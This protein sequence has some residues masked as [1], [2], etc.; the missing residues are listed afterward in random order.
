MMRPKAALL[1][2]IVCL[3]I[4]WAN[5]AL[6]KEAAKPSVSPDKILKK[7]ADRYS[8]KTSLAVALAEF[9]VRTGIEVRVDWKTLEAAGVERKTPVAFDVKDL[10]WRQVLDVML[11]RVYVR[12]T[13]LAWRVE[14]GGI[15]VTTQKQ[16]LADA[17]KTAK[18]IRNAKRPAAAAAKKR[19]QPPVDRAVFG[20]PPAGRAEVLPERTQCELPRQLEGPAG[21]GHHEGHAGLAESQAHQRRQGAGPG[22]ERGQRRQGQARQHLLDHRPRRGPDLHRARTSTARW[23]RG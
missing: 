13:A 18:T 15:F 10:M 6:A 1:W 22:P 19:R 9:A 12:G 21:R 5:Q 11:S 3:G 16:I 14:D 17:A 4:V 20:R 7:T 23:S 8:V 2:A